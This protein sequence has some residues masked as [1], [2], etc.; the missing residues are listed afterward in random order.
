MSDLQNKDAGATGK[1]IMQTTRTT[2]IEGATFASAPTGVSNSNEKCV[3]YKFPLELRRELYKAILAIWFAGERSGGHRG[4][5]HY[6]VDEFGQT[7]PCLA[8]YEDTHGK[9]IWAGVGENCLPAFELAL[10]PEVNFH[11]EFITTR[12]EIS[13]LRLSP[14]VP[15]TYNGGWDPVLKYPSLHKI[16]PKLRSLIRTI[17]YDTESVYSSSA[18]SRHLLTVADSDISMKWV[19]R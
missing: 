5:I 16:S 6:I 4:E 15:R 2:V 18:S 13:V 11:D 9:R 10:L 14:S 17:A 12:I 19:Q 1:T 7:F 3:L 8:R